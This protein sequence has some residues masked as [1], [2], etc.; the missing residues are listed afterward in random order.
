[1]KKT[2]TLGLKEILITVIM[3]IG[4]AISSFIVGL[5]TSKSSN[6]SVTPL[7]AFCILNTVIL[8][9]YILNAKMRG[10]KL[11]GMIF[12]IFWGIQYFMTQIETLYFN[13]AVKMP[14]LDTLKVVIMGAISIFM[15]STFAVL[16]LGKAKNKRSSYGEENIVKVPF[17]KLFPN[18]AILAFCYVIIY[19][20]FGY[21]V[22]WQFPELRKFY[23]GSTAIL[24]VLQ[25]M[26]N[27]FQ[28]DPLLPLFQLFRGLLW[29]G[30]SVIIIHSLNTKG[31]KTYIITG[32]LFSILITSPLILPNAYM[33]APVRLGHSIELFT[34][35][36]AF[37][38][39]SIIIFK[40]KLDIN[41]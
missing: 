10:L 35:M 22:A 38:I 37:G 6:D 26:A 13:S 32:L 30:L 15:S 8:T 14:L 41:V 9:I 11:I 40:N 29:S 7:F 21:F 12:V 20:L 31:W 5:D 28:S 18:M 33:P 34:S 25:H 36:F 24:N 17:A 16:I 4:M 27:Q 1:M 23:T 3:I 19:F 2:I 39:L